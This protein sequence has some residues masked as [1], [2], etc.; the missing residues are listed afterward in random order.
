MTAERKTSVQNSI[1]R[2]A[3]VG[4]GVLLQ[5]FWI[6][7]LFFRLNRYS[8]G[9]SLITDLLACILVLKLYSKRINA[10]FKMPWIILIMAFPLFGVCLYFLIGLPGKTSRQKRKF[11]QIS[12]KLQGKLEQRPEVL[13]A[14]ERQDPAAA[15][16]ARY[17]WKFGGYPIYQHTKVEFYAEADQGL[18]AQKAAIRQAEQFIFMEYHAIEDGESFHG[19]KEILAE[20]AAQ[21]VEVRLIYDDVGSV[22]FINTDFIRRM[23]RLGIQCRVFNPVIPVLS[24]FMNNRD[25]R[26]ITVIDGKVGFTGGYN[27]ADEYFNLTH[28][29][30]RWKD[31]GVKLEGEGVR[32]LTETFLEMWNA[33]RESDE[34]LERYLAMPEGPAEGDG[35]VQP[36]ADSPLDGESLG[37]NV[38]MN[39]IQSAKRYI[40]FTTPY[41]IVDDE[42]ARALELAAKRG[43][44]V[45]IITPGIPDKKLIFQ[46]TRSY[47]A[48]LA[49]GGVRIY[50][51]T[52]GFIH[53][54]QCVCDGE[55]ATVGTINLD[56]RSLYFHFE[57]GVYLYGGEAVS[58]IQRD[59][60]A[61]FPQCNEV[62][63]QYR[64]KGSAALRLGQCILRL[65]APLM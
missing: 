4:A 60:E 53:A 28:P 64:A 42:L 7:F 16:Q 52:P 2:V 36:Y 58:E 56:F 8:A 43:V 63:E 15:N 65:F 22:G 51:Y 35:F 19:L 3:L 24:V 6:F 48:G 29:Y 33:I 46:V 21:G 17:I 31:T 30:G 9:I 11:A 27:L 49:R 55:A 34:D 38:Y 25:H 50:E 10:A 61:T 1:G 13:E 57:N 59:F 44:D 39:L 54:K 23:E 18:E 40:W 41:L 62:T 12:K 45:R 37:E 14:L 26:K 20:K 5:A 47:Y 32:S